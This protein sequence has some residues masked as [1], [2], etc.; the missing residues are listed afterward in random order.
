MVFRYLRGRIREKRHSSPARFISIAARGSAG[1]LSTVIVRGF[2]ACGCASALDEP[3][4]RPCVP[5]SREQ[6]LDRLAEAVHRTS[7]TAA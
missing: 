4:R 6:E 3:L 2:P 1:F 5:P 7:S